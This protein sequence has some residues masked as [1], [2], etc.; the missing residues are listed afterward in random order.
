MPE[1]LQV[2]QNADADAMLVLTPFYIM[3]TQDALAE[4]YKTL[5]QKW[6]CPS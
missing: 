5:D 6:I 2:L 4:F 1:V 3:G